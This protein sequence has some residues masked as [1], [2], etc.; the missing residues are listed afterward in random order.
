VT[1]WDLGIGDS[2]AIWFFQ[3]VGREIHVIDYYEA[4]GA[5][6]G[7]YV[8][9]LLDRR[10]VYSHHILPPTILTAPKRRMNL[11]PDIFF[12]ACNR[13]LQRQSPA[14]S[15]GALWQKRSRLLRGL[16]PEALVY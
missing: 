10:Y 7:H 1:A 11:S 5:D 9:E 4:S 8:R 3:A 2:T 16:A 15:D 13:T 12:L 14:I 6:L